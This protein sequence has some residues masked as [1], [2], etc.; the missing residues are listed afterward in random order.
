MGRTEPRCSSSWR[1][2]GD[3]GAEVIKIEH[4]EGG[5]P[6]RASGPFVEGEGACEAGFGQVEIEDLIAREVIK[7]AD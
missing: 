6:V 3:L 2:S 4:A 5:D 1:T 7:S